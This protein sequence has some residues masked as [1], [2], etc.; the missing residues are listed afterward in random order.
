MRSITHFGLAAAVTLS[1]AVYAQTPSST[2][3]ATTPSSTQTSTGA[4]HPDQRAG[5]SGLH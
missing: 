4:N 1:A 5:S 3:P 2:P